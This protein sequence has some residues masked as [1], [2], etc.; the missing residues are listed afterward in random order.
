[1][2]DSNHPLFRVVLYPALAFA[3]G[4]PI[5]Y[6]L[7][8]NGGLILIQDLVFQRLTTPETPIIAVGP[9]AVLM[10]KVKI[11]LAIGV[12]GAFIVILYTFAWYFTPTNSRIVLV[13]SICAFIAGTVYGYFLAINLS[14]F[15]NL[16]AQTANTA[17]GIPETLKYFI[18]YSFAYGFAAMIPVITY[19][20]SGSEYLSSRLTDIHALVVAVAIFI[21]GNLFFPAIDYLE[22]YIWII[23]A[24]LLFVLSWIALR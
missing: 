19:V 7:L 18:D 14:P 5:A 23:H 16:S 2:G 17:F 6:Y 9:L 12:L 21:V 3:V 22:V 8:E 24:E 1:M 4:T 10:L 13:V 11:A 15:A 20:A